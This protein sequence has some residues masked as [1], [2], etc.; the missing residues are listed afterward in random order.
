MEYQKKKKKECQ[1]VHENGVEWLTMVSRRSEGNGP[2][3]DTRIQ[4]KKGWLWA[5][6]D[7]DEKME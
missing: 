6:G 5:F 4:R 7:Q 1:N 3:Y 2:S